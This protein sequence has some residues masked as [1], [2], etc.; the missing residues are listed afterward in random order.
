MLGKEWA[1]AA[2]AGVIQGAPQRCAGRAKTKKAGMP[3]E[4]LPGLAC[5]VRAGRLAADQKRWRMPAIITRWLSPA[6]GVRLP[7]A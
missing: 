1:D 7:I 4:G 5:L 3:R 6:A 2:R